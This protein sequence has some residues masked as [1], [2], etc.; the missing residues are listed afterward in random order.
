MNYS[1][2]VKNSGV[3]KHDFPVEG[4]CG[5]EIEILTDYENYGYRRQEKSLKGTFSLHK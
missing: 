2:L 4:M 1:A 3:K 5:T